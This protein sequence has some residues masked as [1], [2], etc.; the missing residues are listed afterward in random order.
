MGEQS[1]RLQ[2][3]YETAAT[4][5]TPV[6][7]DSFETAPDGSLCGDEAEKRKPEQ[8]QEHYYD[9]EGRRFDPAVSSNS[10]HFIYGNMK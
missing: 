1:L 2:E 8:Y 4:D 6:K 10:L 9:T 3:S 5:R 7:P